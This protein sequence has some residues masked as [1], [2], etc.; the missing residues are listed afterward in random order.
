M[1]RHYAQTKLNHKSSRSHTIFRIVVKSL[2]NHFISKYRKFQAT[3]T[4]TG[5]IN[6]VNNGDLINSLSKQ[7]GDNIEG[8]VITEA[9]LNFIDLAG[10]EKISN[11]TQTD[12][13]Q[14]GGPEC[15]PI[16]LLANSKTAK[17]RVKEGVHINKSLFFLTQV[18]MMRSEGKDTH[19][20]Y[21]NSPLT[22]ILK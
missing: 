15:Q 21:R 4:N 13:V 6:N 12:D 2:T 20:P 14:K 1:N 18:I 17:Q 16:N 5:L 22:K 11:H 3:Q 9:E 8:A 10:S 7:N 19:I